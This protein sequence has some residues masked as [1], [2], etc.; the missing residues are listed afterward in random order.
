[1]EEE[2]SLR[3]GDTIE[4]EQINVIVKIPKNTMRMTLHCA[5]LP[6]D[7]DYLINV[8]NRLDH[9]AIVQARQDFLDNVDGGDDYDGRFVITDKGREWLEQ[10]EK[11]K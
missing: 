11:N 9:D 3:P 10:M 8:E 2:K 7:S 6:D 5:V 4:L 1:M